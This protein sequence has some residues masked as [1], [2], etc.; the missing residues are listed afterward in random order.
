MHD[1]I[2]SSTNSPGD[3]AREREVSCKGIERAGKAGGGLVRR[4]LLLK[5]WSNSRGWIPG[6][7]VCCSP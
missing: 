1:M 7:E 5:I 3:V 4:G 2:Q 6:S